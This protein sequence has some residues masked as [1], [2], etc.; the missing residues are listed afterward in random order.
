V[1]ERVQILKK[2]QFDGSGQF[3]E[4]G[5]Q[6]LRHGEIRREDLFTC[7]LISVKQSIL[8]VRMFLVSLLLHN[9]EFLLYCR[10]VYCRVQP[11]SGKQMLI[12]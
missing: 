7:L 2:K 5:T 6:R 8:L 4:K 10:L 1:P 3:E 9:E 11:R 12:I